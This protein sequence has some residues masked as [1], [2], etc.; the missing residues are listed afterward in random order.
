LWKHPAFFGHKPSKSNEM[1]MRHMKA[2]RQAF[3]QHFMCEFGFA[4]SAEFQL[5][6]LLCL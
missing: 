3:D 1:F 6:V 4:V 2:V 5:E